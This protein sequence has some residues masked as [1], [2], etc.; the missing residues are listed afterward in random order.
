MARF[1]H[2]ADLHLNA[3]RIN[4]RDGYLPRAAW[5]LDEIAKMATRYDCECIVVAGDVFDRPDTTIAERQLL[6]DW[7]GA[8]EVPAILISGNHDSRSSRFGDTCLSY[9]SALDL[10]KHFV[11]DGMPRI[12]ERFG[13]SWLLLPHHGW[14]DDEFHLIV[15]AM[16]EEARPDLPRVVVC[17]EAV[18]G[19]R[20][21][22]DHQLTKSKYIKLRERSDV[23]YWAM[24]DIHKPQRLFSNGYYAGSP[25]QINFGEE[26][27]RGVL[28]VDTETVGATGAGFVEIETPFPLITLDQTPRDGVW[29]EFIKFKPDEPYRDPLPEHVVYEPPRQDFD[30]I[31]MPESIA[32]LFHG[33]EA[34]L[35]QTD[36]DPRLIPLALSVAEDLRHE[37]LRSEENGSG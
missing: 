17:H 8:L 22:S 36:L 19:C 18:Y 21:D 5:V 28:L 16:L 14:K 25:H 15:E 12:E 33:L 20:T 30:E 1:L 37:V 9:L 13:C 24:G 6:S 31:E 11:H 10:G 34:R 35:A 2:T 23:S 3:L 27:K 26:Q 29:P 7:L 4:H 32:D